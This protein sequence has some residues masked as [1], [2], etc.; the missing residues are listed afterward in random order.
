MKTN[1]S[2]S[3]GSQIRNLLIV[4]TSGIGLAVLLAFISLYYYNPSGS[5][6]A[7]NVLLSPESL[8]SIRFAESSTSSGTPRFIFDN[9]EF[10]FYNQALKKWEKKFIS[11]EQ[12]NTFYSTLSN[13]KSFLEVPPEV[14]NA[15]HKLPPVTLALKVRTEGLANAQTP[16]TVVTS[17][18]F[19]EG[20]YYR[21]QLR[22][23]A[24]Q[25]SSLGKWVYFHQPD[26]YEKILK[27]FNATQWIL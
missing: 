27:I 13:E 24:S 26:I 19:V 21:I 12:Y 1:N 11:L 15:F 8:S 2:T 18:E 3:Q 7:K 22:E 17:V 6:L 10:S 5:Y 9:L 14:E 4:F 20:D 16:S 23:Q 25:T